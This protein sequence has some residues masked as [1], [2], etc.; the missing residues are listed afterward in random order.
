MNFLKSIF[1]QS[2]T[3]YTLYDLDRVKSVLKDSRVEKDFSVNINQ[4]DK[5]LFN[6]KANSSIGVGITNT[7][8]SQSIQVYTEIGK[9]DNDRIQVK[10]FT[11]PRWDLM[12]FAFLAFVIPIIVL[13]VSED[14]KGIAIAIGV[15]YGFF[16]WFR[17]I[18][19]LQEKAIFESLQKVLKLKSNISKD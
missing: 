10:I 16:F 17:M 4:I 1:T 12:I 3:Y 14:W 15:I 2:V 18:Y 7:G 6:V 19:R 8:Y 11:K 5:L 13:V 9:T